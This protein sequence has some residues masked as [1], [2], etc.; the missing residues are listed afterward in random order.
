VLP[1]ERS[2]TFAVRRLSDTLPLVNCV[3]LREVSPLPLPVNESAAL[4]K[5]SAPEY[6]P[7]RAELGTTL[8]N[9]AALR[10]VKPPPFPMNLPVN[11]PVNMSDGLLNVT[12]LP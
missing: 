6:V 10:F 11:V 2:A 7:A 4:L 8:V 9:C 1:P 3:A 5:V 12:A